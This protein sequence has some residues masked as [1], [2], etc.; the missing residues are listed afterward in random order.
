MLGYDGGRIDLVAAE[1]LAQTATID[2]LWSGASLSSIRPGTGCHEGVAL[3]TWKSV[4]IETS[5]RSR[6]NR[7]SPHHV[8]YVS[9]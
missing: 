4:Y 7:N 1:G 3:L 9:A 2:T 5:G 8:L 6:P